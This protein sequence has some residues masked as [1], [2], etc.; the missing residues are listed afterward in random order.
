M[1]VKSEYATELISIVKG[2]TE[3]PC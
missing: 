1:I 3:W 2:T